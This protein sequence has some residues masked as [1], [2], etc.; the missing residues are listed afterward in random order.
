MGIGGKA[1]L[2]QSFFTPLYNGKQKTPS[3]GV[4][5]REVLE[6]NLFLSF[7]KVV[8]GLSNMADLSNTMGTLL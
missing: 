2:L 6:I 8:L 4:R 3:S 7:I 5:S 1:V